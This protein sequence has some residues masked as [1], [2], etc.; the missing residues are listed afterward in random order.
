MSLSPKELLEEIGLSPLWV[1]RKRPQVAR[2]SAREA[3]EEVP[4]SESALVESPS[5]PEA[6]AAHSGIAAAVVRVRRANELGRV[7]QE[8]RRVSRL[9]V[10]CAAETG[11]PWCG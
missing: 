3:A 2:P 10:V 4:A 6:V 7:A 1:L 11:S 8:Y 9:R 5:L